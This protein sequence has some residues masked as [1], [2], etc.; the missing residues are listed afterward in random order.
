M[1]SGQLGRF[2]DCLCLQQGRAGGHSF[3]PPE[4]AIWRSIVDGVPDPTKALI[5]WGSNPL[6]NAA[7]TRLVKEITVFASRLNGSNLKTVLKADG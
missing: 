2:R 4:R 6:L 7:N 1:G 5:T 3:T